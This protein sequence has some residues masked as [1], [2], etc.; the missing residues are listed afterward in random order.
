MKK[1][2]FVEKTGRQQKENQ[3][4]LALNKQA[5]ENTQNIK[6]QSKN[7]PENQTLVNLTLAS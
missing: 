7:T 4:D 5:L 2:L 1:T 6:T 3:S